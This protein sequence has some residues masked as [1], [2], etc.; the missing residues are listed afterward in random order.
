L[1]PLS[2]ASNWQGQEG[3][4]EGTLQFSEGESG[5]LMIAEIKLIDKKTSFLVP[6]T[7]AHAGEFSGTLERAS[8]VD[9]FASRREARKT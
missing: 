2:L 1:E 8:F 7:D 3:E 4:Y 9:S 5:D 6:G